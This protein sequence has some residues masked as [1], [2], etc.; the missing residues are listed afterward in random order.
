[1]STAAQRKWYGARL[2]Q[3]TK[4]DAR[5]EFERDRDRVLYSFEFTRL[6]G[7]TQ[8]S[9]RE[10]G[11][12]LHNRLTHSLKV[13]Q[14]ARRIAQRLKSSHN[15]DPVVNLMNVDAVET[16]GLAHDLGHPPFGHVAEQ[17]LDEAAVSFGGFNGNAQTFRI[18]TRLSIGRRDRSKLTD[19]SVILDPRQGLNL[20]RGSLNAILKYPWL[21]DDYD[22]LH[23][24]KFGA[25][26]EDEELLTWVRKTVTATNTVAPPSSRKSLEAHIMDWADDVTYAVHDFQDFANAGLINIEQLADRNSATYGRFDEHLQRHPKGDELRRRLSAFSQRLNMA[27]VKSPPELWAVNLQQLFSGTIHDA[28]EKVTLSPR[29]TTYPVI[30][31]PKR[32]LDEV[33]ML[34][35]SIWCFVIEHDSSDLGR[36]QQFQKTVVKTVAQTYLERVTDIT[37]LRNALPDRWRALVSPTS[38]NRNKRLIID[39]I[40]GMT[41][42]EILVRFDLLTGRDSQRHYEKLASVANQLSL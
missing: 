27:V 22:H 16:A 4:S 25:Y 20:T 37:W 13:A 7:V 33:E 1:M 34:K 10:P 9:D 38:V 14:V 2:A 11:V 32:V 23:R 12:V 6:V 26:S 41:E 3:E 18:V 17:V 36:R 19:S 24:A 35:Q 42:E 40:S 39:F 8:V 5:N 31:V 15:S 21:R 29:S 28:I 30:R